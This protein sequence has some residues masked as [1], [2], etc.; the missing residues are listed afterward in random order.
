MKRCL[1]A[2]LMLSICCLCRCGTIYGGKCGENA[3]WTFDFDKEI[4]TISGYGDMTDFE[5]NEDTPWFEH[6]WKIA[7]IVIGDSITS[8]GSYSFNIM[9]HCTSVTLGNSLFSIHEKAFYYCKYIKK[10]VIPDNVRIIGRQ[11]FSECSGITSI[12]MGENVER[13]E[14]GAFSGLNNLKEVR[15]KSLTNWLGI[16]FENYSS[17]PLYYA[18]NLYVDDQLTKNLV[19]PEGI[20][21]V[22]K[23]S[24]CNVNIDTL[25]LPSTL[26]HFDVNSFI[27]RDSI[28]YI[29]V[30]PLNKV[31]DSREDCNAII[32]TATN[33][34]VFGGNISTIPNS[35][36]SI[37]DSAFYGCRSMT[38]ISIP[39]SV[40]SIGKYSFWCCFKLVEINIP[41]GVKEIGDYTFYRCIS[42]T[43]VNIPSS[44]TSIGNSAF[45]NCEKL[46]KAVLGPGITSIGNS[47]FSYCSSLDSLAFMSAEAP[48]IKDNTFSNVKENG[49]IIFPE[50]SDYI[51]LMMNLKEGSLAYQGWRLYNQKKPML[52]EIW[53]TTTDDKIMNPNISDWSQYNYYVSKIYPSV[54]SNSYINGMGVIRFDM[55]VPY[56][57]QKCFKG[58]KTITS[59]VLPDSIDT[60]YSDAF[61]DCIKLNMVHL[62]EQ[63]STIADNCF[64]GCE[65][66]DSLYIPAGFSPNTI[67]TKAFV[68]IPNLRKVVVSEDNKTFDSRGNCNGIILTEKNELVL[69]SAETVIPRSVKSI[70]DYAFQGNKSLESLVIPDSVTT[71]GTS[72][73]SD[74]IGLKAVELPNSIKSIGSS[75]FLGCKSLTSIELPHS[76]TNIGNGAFSGCQKLVF[77]D[78]PDKCNY[79]PTINGCTMLKHLTIGSNILFVHQG[80]IKN[81]NNIQSITIKT[82]EAPNIFTNYSDV[83]FYYRPSGGGPSI[84]YRPV[85]SDYSKWM[86]S[87]TYMNFTEDTI[88]E[89]KTNELWY[90]TSDGEPLQLDNDMSEKVV[91]NG[92]KAGYGI[93]QYETP[94]TRIEKDAFKNSEL[95]TSMTIPSTVE[96]IGDSAFAKCN[97]LRN[98]TVEWDTP[99]TISDNVFDSSMCKV[100]YVPQNTRRLYERA[101]GWRK[102]QKIVQ[103][104]NYVEWVRFEAEERSVREGDTLMV[105]ATVFPD[106]AVIRDLNWYSSD[107]TVAIVKNGMVIGKKVGTVYVKAVTKD[108]TLL[109][110]S[111]VVKVIPVLAEDV[112]LDCR[113][114]RM[115]KEHTAQLKVE[116]SP[117]RT[118]YKDVTWASSDESILKVESGIIT[119]FKAGNATVIATTTDGT[120]LTAQCEVKVEDYFP[121]D[122]NWDSEFNIADVTGTVSFITEKNTEGLVFDA[123][124][125]NKDGIVLVNDLKDVLD[126]VLAA[127]TDQ[128][129]ERLSARKVSSRGEGSPELFVSDCQYISSTNRNIRIG[130]VNADKF[131]GIQCD[132]VLPEGISL[133]KACSGIDMGNHHI[134]TKELD[135]RTIR[136]AVYSMNNECFSKNAADFLVLNLKTESGGQ[137]N[138]YMDLQNIIVSTI[139][140]KTVK[141]DDITIVAKES[142]FTGITNLPASYNEKMYTK[143][144]NLNGV[145][146]DDSYRGLVLKKGRKMVV[147]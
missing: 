103:P 74:C 13:V 23:Y 3:R 48:D 2:F 143:T 130:L 112:K 62:P 126:V 147:K 140:S 17:N 41:N 82:R 32:E 8:I 53:Y 25:S 33:R 91:S 61:Y 65:S 135:D 119:A 66:L 78:I 73:F 133:S 72:S 104:Y 26:S 12:D 93:I 80:D 70:G 89:R 92:Y 102:F 64:Y 81:C 98:M 14:A 36:E 20:D 84:F 144:Y 30:N 129:A 7:K 47:A 76:I 22:R 55:V 95:L 50:E 107:E 46:K 18:S 56:I 136:V 68:N 128:T 58:N 111:C 16:Y 57:P 120:S 108:G 42:L 45:W 106:D 142:Q 29:V 132:L 101:P 113:F 4:L 5:S 85:G 96:E 35:I 49:M 15:I 138:F 131:T 31:F 83:Y 141:L 109:T 79:F 97:N 59:V 134:V 24:F 123:A 116:V 43:E 110:D 105:N 39:E 99:I 67:Y 34:L 125:M 115:L 137:D 88:P 87:L 38:D 94:V 100:L 52:N 63:L 40:C 86:S 54:I 139:L 114:V 9:S 71:I 19:I 28:K 10:L 1:T 127:S 121:A 122:V 145:V 75:A 60:I 11:A 77:L 90:R 146:V 6:K 69:G 27:N 51:S 21:F 124:D 117:Y 118:T 37:G 44:V